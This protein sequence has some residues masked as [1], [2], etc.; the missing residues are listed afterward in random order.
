MAVRYGVNMA[1]G[2]NDDFLPGHNRYLF[3]EDL[4]R[5]QTKALYDHP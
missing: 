3:I 2:R 5:D 4:H 1:G